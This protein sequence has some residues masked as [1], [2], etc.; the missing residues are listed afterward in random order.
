MT[1]LGGPITLV[2]AV[3]GGSGSAALTSFLVYLGAVFALAWLSTRQR[4]DGGFINEYFLGSR[5]LGVWAF[6]L[7]FAATSASGGSFV[8]FPALIYTHGW[9]LALWIAGYMLVPL[10]AMGLMGKRLNR[11]SRVADAVTIPDVIERRFASPAAGIVATIL[12]VL[13]MFYFLLAQFKAGSEILAILLHGVPAFD[14][15]VGV[16]AGVTH[17]WSWLSGTEPDYVLCLAVFSAAVIIYVVYGGFRAVVWTDVMQGIIMFLGVVLLLG[18]ALYFTGGLDAATQQLAKRQPPAFGTATLLRTSGTDSG[19]VLNKGTWL[20]TN[21]GGLVRTRERVEI[22]ANRTL[23]GNV[24]ILYLRSPEDQAMVAQEVIEG[25][26]Q[27]TE[28]MLAPLAF[29]QDQPGTYLYPPGPSRENA[30]GFLSLSMAFSFFVF[31]PFGAAGQPSNLVRLMAFRNTRI[32]KLSIAT[33]AVYYSFIYFSLVI[34]FCCARVLLPGMEMEADRVMPQMAVTSTVRAGV[35]WLAGFLLAAPFAA[36]MS[37]VDSF[38][39]LVSSSLVRDIYQRYLH[40]KAEEHLLKRVTYAGTIVVG[41]LATYGALRPPP[42]LQVI[43]VDA[44]GFLAAS[45]L[46]PVAFSL[47]WKRMTPAGAI[48][49][50]LGGCAMHAMF[51]FRFAES[52]PVLR[53]I[54]SL[55]FGPLVWDLLFSTSGVLIVSKL[56][57]PMDERFVGRYFA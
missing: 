20:S 18:F 30:L 53:D 8:G 56:T 37:S 23:L 29:G 34:I 31:W 12:I 41:L 2:A 25:G 55:Q 10:V 46:A 11:V 17:S 35:P 33:V 9:V 32:L 14:R 5:N 50:M 24:P 4:S 3:N 51:S 19:R 40:P 16:V 38:L 7:T 22:A 48:A 54:E 6:A 21:E 15:A 45:F 26:W 42:Y 57:R 27:A 39:L 13:F 47:Y 43:I 36:V 28:L 44:S 49:G 1:E 52:L